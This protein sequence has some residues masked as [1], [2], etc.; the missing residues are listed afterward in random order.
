MKE[1]LVVS[2]KIS[3][4]LLFCLMSVLFLAGCNDNRTDRARGGGGAYVDPNA[5][6]YSLTFDSGEHGTNDPIV[7][8]IPSGGYVG[9]DMPGA[10]TSDDPTGWFF[11]GWYILNDGGDRIALTPTST[12][13]SDTVVYA[14]WTNVQTFV[15]YFNMNSSDISCINVGL[16]VKDG[17]TLGLGLPKTPTNGTQFFVGWYWDH[18]NDS[19]TPE[20]PFT[21]DTP[22]T[23]DITINAHWSRTAVFYNVT[24]NANGGTPTETVVS[25][26]AGAAVDTRMPK[27]T[28]DL[29]NFKGWSTDSAAT[30][31]NFTASTAVVDNV[32][33]Y[34][35][36]SP[37]AVTPPEPT[38]FTVTFFNNDGTSSILTT[39]D[40]L[41]NTSVGFDMP[42]ATRANYNF[43]RWS[44][45]S[46]GGTTFAQDTVV[47]QDMSVYAIWTQQ[48]TY[49]NVTFDPNG[50]TGSPIVVG[51]VSGGTVGAAQMPDPLPTRTGYTFV[52]WGYTATGEPI[53]TA[54]TKV[55]EPTTVYAIWSADPAP[56]WY[57]V[58]FVFDNGQDNASFTVLSGGSVGA[59]MPTNPAKEGFDFVRWSANKDG[60]TNFTASTPITRDMVIY[61]I[62]AAGTPVEPEPTMFTVTFYQNDGT[63]MVVKSVQVESG[64]PVDAEMP[65]PTRAEYNFEHWS[66]SKAGD[67]N[68]NSMTPVSENMNLYA[69][70]TPISVAP[71]TYSVTFVIDSSSVVVSDIVS[72]QTISADQFPPNPAKTGFTFLGW[73]A[74]PT[75]AATFTQSTKV[76]SNMTVYA[77]WE[78]INIP[79]PTLYTV[80]FNVVGGTPAIEAIGDIEP[81]TTLGDLM[82]G[83][84]SK[85]GYTFQGWSTSSTGTVADFSASV[86]VGK[87]MTVYAIW[88]QDPVV[89]TY[90]VTFNAMG[91]EPAALTSLTRATGAPIGTLPTVTKGTLIFGG[92]STDKA[93]TGIVSE[94][95][96]VGQNL[97]LSALWYYEVWFDLD[98]DGVKDEPDEVKRVLEGS[99]FGTTLPDLEDTDTDTF[100]GWV[101]GSGNS[102]GKGTI[103]DENTPLPLE[104]HPVWTPKIIYNTVTFVYND[105]A[106]SDRVVQVPDNSVISATIATPVFAAHIFKG[107]TT[108]V[109]DG[110]TGTANFN[111]KTATIT[112]SM[113]VYAIW[114][115]SFTITINT[116]TDNI[117]LEIE[118]GTSLGALMPADPT[119]DG[120]IFGGWDSN[121]D[122]VADFTKDTVINGPISIVPVFTPDTPPPFDVTIDLGD[123]TEPIVIEDVEYGTSL[124]SRMPDSPV[125]TEVPDDPSKEYFFAGWDSDGDGIADFTSTT[126][127]Y[128]E[129]DDPAFTL[130]AVWDS[131]AVNYTV[132]F[133][134]NGGTGGGTLTVAGGATVG[135][136]LP[137]VTMADSALLD[138][139][140]AG[141]STIKNGTADFT[142]GTPVSDN[143]T[144][145]AKWS[146]VPVQY[147]V[148]F[149]T[150]NDDLN[151]TEH[152]VVDVAAGSM[153]ALP[154]SPTRAAE[155]GTNVTFVGWSRT[156]GATTA[157]FDATTPITSDLSLYSVWNET[158]IPYTVTF[159]R[160]DGSPDSSQIS[161]DYGTTIGAQMP[162]DLAD[163]T[164][165]AFIEW[166]ASPSGTG[167]TITADTVVTTAMG[168]YGKWSPFRTITLPDGSTEPVVDGCTMSDPNCDNDTSDSIFPIDPTP[169]SGQVFV[170]WNDSQ[171]GRGNEIT[172]DTIIDGDTTLYPVFAK[173]VADAAAL[174]KITDNLGGKYVLTN[175]ININGEFTPIG[176][177]SFLG[178]TSCDAFTG[179]LYGNDYSVIQAEVT[180]S[181]NA[182][183]FCE[184]DGGYVKDL[185]ITGS[186]ASEALINLIAPLTVGGLTST[187]TD[188]VIKNSCFT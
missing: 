147:S 113:S 69:I 158:L 39:R 115:E 168:V 95:T 4:M 60:S 180:S 179:S 151:Y 127:I 50:G 6:M 187:A 144:V 148:T 139:S 138:Y 10:P 146:S 40:V 183:F 125:F 47:S 63:E 7:M 153:V 178:V 145:Y 120:E 49:N 20:V 8:S 72:G 141:W 175:D 116:G 166:N 30:V 66:L 165:L 98:G 88:S 21:S 100:D 106:T 107:W 26:A 19:S 162:A 9:Q 90:T 155:T 134:P 81:N 48:V 73:G 57:K 186:V 170:E 156:Q 137:T 52:G 109:T 71:T 86:P 70:W 28:R 79:T 154:Q 53:F 3:K 61:A 122:G 5:T 149:Y 108:T 171:D 135:S 94:N 157:N 182:G 74:T 152:A 176:Q 38:Y 99:S 1:L 185:N 84:P 23:E 159:F 41:E 167:V 174:A 164:T 51:V 111:P 35:I 77:L 62:W 34:A 45:S 97:T 64:K 93:A 123:G 133:D 177:S 103:I 143:M 54:D 75:G 46:D 85:D 16:R 80:T 142:A 55:V 105:L 14:V 89:V 132:I 13:Y 33:V 112:D 44:I 160:N 114:A 92:W 104:L 110:T 65:V 96:L 117:T 87:S 17:S 67:S 140:F 169:P 150:S 11:E 56:V 2:S 82:P 43:Q 58:T 130:V 129:E 15:A 68:F 188:S 31:S 83:N 118:K 24:F 22:I 128:Q 119:K 161:V 76:T 36:W 59:Q 136:N 184:M 172:E 102:F 126:K 25:V 37:I 27:V 173:P 18:D 78:E 124:G 91:G 12:I 32:T 42:T 121:G 29:F 131:V 181:G 101:D 163:T